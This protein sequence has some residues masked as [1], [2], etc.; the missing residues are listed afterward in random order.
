MKISSTG[1]K[2]SSTIAEVYTCKG[3]NINPELGWT[4]VP[5]GTQTLALIVD[6]PDAPAGLWTHW[7]VWNIDPA[8]NAIAENYVP[9][10]AVEGITSAGSVGYHGP[11]PPNGE[12]RYFFKLFALDTKLTLPVGAN[13]A[14]L[15]KVME[16]HVLEQT[17]LMGFFQK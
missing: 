12:H 6:D 8:L 16:G 4:G 10:N 1:F 15:E 5:H 11:C 7:L 2:D 14:D 9:L 13:R 17:Y 3:K